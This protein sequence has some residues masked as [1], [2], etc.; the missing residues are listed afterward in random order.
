MKVYKRIA[1]LLSAAAMLT[2]V[3]CGS[4]ESSSK[5]EPT[6]A[7]SAPAAESQA[8]EESTPVTESKSDGSAEKKTV[9][10]G[11][12]MSVNKS[13]GA[14]SIERAGQKST[15]MGDE[16][17]WTVFVYLCGTDLESGHG[18]A[19]GDIKQMLAAEGSDNVSFVFQTG[20]TSA[21]QKEEISSGENQR[22]VVRNGEMQ[23]AD[24]AELTNMG[25]PDTLTDFL[26]W[27]VEN[28]PAEKMGVIFW[29]HGGGSIAG[30]CFD[31]LNEGNGLT[32]AEM[33]SSFSQVYEDMTDQFEFIGFD[34]CLMGTAE[35]ANI[36]ATYA[37]YFY[38]S[39]ECE[40]GTGWDY[41]TIGSYLAQE[42]AA[43]G[44]DLGKVVAESFYEEC[45][46]GGAENGATLTVVDLSKFDE[47]AAAF[48]DYSRT[49]YEGAAENFAGIVRGIT[50]ADNFGGNNKSEG[51][52]NMVDMGGI[53]SNCASVA[54]GS[55]AMKAL[56]DCIVFNKNGADHANASGLSVYYPLK[57]Q[58][59]DELKN[60]SGLALNPYYLSIVDRI[61][62]GNTGEEYT[63]ESLFDS[64]G[65]WESINC[66][67]NTE[68]DYFEGKNI[69][70]TEESRLITFENEPAQ[71]ENGGYGFKL[72]AS[73]LEN[74][75]SIEALIY[76]TNGNGLVML[77]ETTDVDIDLETG[78]VTDNF[79]GGWLTLAGAT[80]LAT[81]IADTA[82]GYTL[83]TSPIKLNGKRTNLRIRVDADYSVSVEGAWDGV[84]ENGAASR[85][86]TKLKKGDKIVPLYYLEDETEFEGTEYDWTGKDDCGYGYLPEGFYLYAFAINDVY[87]DFLTTAPVLFKID[88]DGKMTFVASGAEETGEGE[89]AEEMEE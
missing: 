81:F 14:L 77:G 37:R 7:E 32:L 11:M 31:E 63:N 57:V 61:V 59:A 78:E 2:A 52:T 4:E 74:T 58:N 86:I 76:Y 48:N 33:N 84:D 36:M 66:S 55:A 22:F 25:D 47:F 9:S 49:L 20:G 67:T 89:E 41:T 72:D 85:E 42:P 30:A 6:T 38:G 15:P 53:F 40:P 23:L 13:S 46:Q 1:A 60:F 21:W 75:A 28:Y 35:T 10:S 73:G 87:G 39:Q 82:E 19:T 71:N 88:K 29:D 70:K 45:A 80:P 44:G 27:G 3:G 5:A 24:S 54:D 43:N 62:K 12:K 56:R 64:E 65:N 16:G 83:Y 34:C 17:T 51:Y 79:D 26:K 50:T 8:A 69:G 18:S 68:E